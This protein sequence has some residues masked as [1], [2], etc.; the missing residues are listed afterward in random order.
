MLWALLTIVG[1]ATVSRA[2]AALSL[3]FTLPGQE[4]YE[5]NRSIVKTYGLNSEDPPLVPT[6][7]LPAGTTVDSPGIRANLDN[8]FGNVAAASPGARVISYASTGDRGFVSKD[9]RTTFALVHPAPTAPTFTSAPP[10]VQATQAALQDVR[11]AG[12]PFHL[13]GINALASSGGGGSGPGV[14]TETIIG[15]AGALIVVA[16]V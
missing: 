9:G 8:A 4:S 10:A 7:T 12:A 15:G 14:L 3:K 5:T 2:T 16:V 11:I 6:I 1:G 13:T